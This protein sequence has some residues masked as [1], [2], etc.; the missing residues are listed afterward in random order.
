M[1]M[2]QKKSRRCSPV[3]VAMLSLLSLSSFSALSSCTASQEEAYWAPLK[4]LTSHPHPFIKV[5]SAIGAFAGG[6]VGIPVAIA[7]LPLTT[8]VGAVNDVNLAP[9]TPVA[10]VAQLGA[11]L[12][13]G[14][15]WLL[16]GWWGSE[17]IPDKKS[18][19]ASESADDKTARSRSRNAGRT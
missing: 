12:T 6:V 3:R 17:E 14:P 5:P 16:F 10:V 7:S 15:M 9:L 2:K 13:G 19:E 18:G 4:E 11:I 1:I 8:V